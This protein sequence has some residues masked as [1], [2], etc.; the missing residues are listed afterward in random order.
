[1]ALRKETEL[2]IIELEPLVRQSDPTRYVILV[3]SSMTTGSR[4]PRSFDGTT[5]KDR[6][7]FFSGVRREIV[8]R[9]TP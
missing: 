3:A 4:I 9:R 2:L 1:M 6:Y 7:A 8:P 5:D